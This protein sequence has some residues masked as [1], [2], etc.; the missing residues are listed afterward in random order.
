M[1]TIETTELEISENLKKK[2]DMICKFACVKPKYK[3]FIM[4]LIHM[5]N[6]HNHYKSQILPFNYA[7]NIT[8]DELKNEILNIKNHFNN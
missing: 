1:L 2:V 5:L 7:L 6:Q 8:L 4:K 3:R